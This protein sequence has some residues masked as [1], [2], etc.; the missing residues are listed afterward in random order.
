MGEKVSGW[1]E[2]GGSYSDSN[3]VTHRHITT[4]SVH[5]VLVN[6]KTKRHV[7]IGKEVDDS[8]PANIGVLIATSTVEGNV[9]NTSQRIGSHEV[10]SV[11][12][13]N[14]NDGG[15]HVVKE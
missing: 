15:E 7:R 1:I 3:S 11:R 5:T 8:T 4:L 2:K 13:A 6:P 9:D 12:S 10:H 14:R